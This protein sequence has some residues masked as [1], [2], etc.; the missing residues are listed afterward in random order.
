MAEL[1]SLNCPGSYSWAWN[2]REVREEARGEKV[3]RVRVGS[4]CVEE[5]WR[6]HGVNE[7]PIRASVLNYTLFFL[8]PRSS[9]IPSAA[10]LHAKRVQQSRAAQRRAEQVPSAYRPS[11]PVVPCPIVGGWPAMMSS[12]SSPSL[13]L[14]LLLLLATLPSAWA[15]NQPTESMIFPGRHPE[16]YRSLSVAI[17]L[18]GPSRPVILIHP[19]TP[20]CPAVFGKK[21]IVYF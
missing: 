10:H 1:P 7:I 21:L 20:H 11:S 3:R 8:A 5:S 2:R 16:A 4:K 18:I 14:S 12:S 15:A 17:S 13:S 9:P 19:H 6:P